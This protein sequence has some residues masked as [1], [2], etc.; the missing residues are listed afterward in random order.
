MGIETILKQHISSI[1]YY[2]NLP[3]ILVNGSQLFETD[4]KYIHKDLK[5]LNEL[6]IINPLK[7][8]MTDDN[9]TDKLNYSSLGVT[10]SKAINQ[11]E[12]SAVSK[13]YILF[14]SE[15]IREQKNL[16]DYI[17]IAEFIRGF[18]HKSDMTEKELNIFSYCINKYF[19]TNLHLFVHNKMKVLY[20]ESISVTEE[21]YQCL[22]EDEGFNLENKRLNDF[23]KKHNQTYTIINDYLNV[24]SYTYTK[25][26]N[27][28]IV[29]LLKLYVN[30]D[31]ADV[32][33]QKAINKI[34]DVL[35]NC[36]DF[37][38]IHAQLD[39]INENIDI[40]VDDLRKYTKNKN[41]KIIKR[42]ENIIA[43]FKDATSLLICKKQILILFFNKYLA[44]LIYQNYFKLYS[45][46]KIN[47]F[48]VGSNFK[49]LEE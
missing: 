16:T 18:I 10:V 27:S 21:L 38:K 15:Y 29:D 20:L 23:T 31:K 43:A 42:S 34:L 24:L 47:D 4:D 26:L 25:S 9:L 6:N 5:R 28:A 35:E 17:S 48:C 12:I 22:K 32:K 2:E 36:N 3:C 11:F 8:I 45:I 33:T 19:H 7:K 40:I 41:E 39:D 46:F 30:P 1:K 37:F 14:I 49:E 13:K 44:S